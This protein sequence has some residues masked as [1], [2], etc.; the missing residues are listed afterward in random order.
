MA[1]QQTI[2]I[3]TRGHHES[4]RRDCF[5]G[6]LLDRANEYFVP[7]AAVARLGKYTLR[8]VQGQGRGFIAQRPVER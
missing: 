8:N 1:Y 3:H 7:E 2:Q 6:R 5:E 4:M